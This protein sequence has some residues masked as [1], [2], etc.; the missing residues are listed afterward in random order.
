MFTALGSPKGA[1]I[2]VSAAAL[3]LA[4]TYSISAAPMRGIEIVRA[5]PQPVT[6]PLITDTTVPSDEPIIELARNIG[7]VEVGA[8]VQVLADDPAAALDIPA[9]CEMRAQEY[10]GEAA[11]D[12]GRA[13]LVRRRR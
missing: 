12:Q 2:G 3:I 1:L 11:S 7:R 6:A 4:I 9:W 13:F 8:V 5:A 10:V